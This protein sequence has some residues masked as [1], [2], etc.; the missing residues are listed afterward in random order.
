MRKNFDSQT[1]L[2][3]MVVLIVGTYDENGNANAMTAAWGGI[4]DTRQI[5]V[6]ID[7]GHQTARNLLCRKEFTVSIG[8]EDQV[9]SCDYVGLVSAKDE[10][11][12]LQKAKFHPRKAEFVDAPYFEELP[13]TLE[14][15]LLHYDAVTGCA[16]ADI[17]NVSAEDSILDENGA[18]D[19]EKL[20][21]ILFDPVHHLYR[22]MGEVAGKAFQDGLQL[23]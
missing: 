1:W 12:K 18:I 16:V 10:P 15:R 13:M 5:A 11:Q 2:Y 23:K 6:C 19:P 9:V 21:P 14:C 17:V 20:R 22:K 4:H 7:P 3:P 8:T